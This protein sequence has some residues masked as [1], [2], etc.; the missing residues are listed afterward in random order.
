MTKMNLKTKLGHLVL[1]VMLSATSLITLQAQTLQHIRNATSKLHY[2][3]KTFLIDPMFAPKGYYPGFDGT[4]HSERRNPLVDLPMS[5]SQVLQGID[6]VVVTH[7]HS[8]HW[9][10]FAQQLI[11]KDLP[12]LVQNTAD[13]NLIRSQGFRHVFIIGTDTLPFDGITLSSIRGTHGTAEMY[14]VSPLAEMLGETIG[15]VFRAKGQKTIYLAGDTIWTGE[16]SQ[17]I[18]QYDPDVIILNAGYAQVTGFEGS[19][20]MGKDD[21]LRATQESKTAKV[22]SV[23]MEAVNHCLLSRT[24]L[25]QFVKQHKIK[26]R[27]RI[28]KDGQSLRL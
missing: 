23:H 3:G 21:V 11:D 13:A 25:K 20:I 12:I 26:H 2:A 16:V 6:A 27:V 18:N 17:A 10:D 1:F 7:T 24:D 22:V 28:P 19:I 14:A 8:D 4:P 15:I 9:D 5:T